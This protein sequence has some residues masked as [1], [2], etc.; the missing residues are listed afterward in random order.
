MPDGVVVVDAGGLIVYVNRQAE[1][2]T[3]YG[4]RELLGRPIELLVPQRFRANHRENRRDY[5]A[6]QGAR[7]MGSAGHDFTVRR[8]DGT[9]FSADIA[10]GPIATAGGCNVVA[11]IRDMTERRRFEATLEH[12][13]L[14]DP[15]TD[16]ANRNLFFDRLKQA[17]LTGRRDGRSVAIV[18]L[19][20][21]R[22]KLVNDRFGHVVG[23]AALKELAARLQARLRKTDTA[24]RLGGDEFA[25]ILPGV[26]DRAAAERMVR[27][28]LHSVKGI[29]SAAGEGIEVGVSAGMALY[30]D[31]GADVD[32]LMVRADRALYAAKRAGHGFASARL[33]C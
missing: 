5:H 12:Q 15:L 10:L 9:E 4:R 23:D 8:K 16:L 20:L 1:R 17:I 13:A 27:K 21:D 19:D 14:H 32:T 18:M 2:I 24:A 26:A 30:P 33:A 6:H 28:L 7:S 22:F 31:D 11:V 29:I 25:W 3:G